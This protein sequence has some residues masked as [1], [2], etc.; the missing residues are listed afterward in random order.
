MI[1]TLEE[2]LAQL[3]QQQRYLEA[4]INRTPTG[5]KR[6]KLTHANIHLM[7]AMQAIRKAG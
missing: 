6:N 1:P 5:D 2:I 7:G 3:E 4:H